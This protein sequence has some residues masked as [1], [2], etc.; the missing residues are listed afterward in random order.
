MTEANYVGFVFSFRKAKVGKSPG[1]NVL[2]F[3]S[4]KNLV[5]GWKK[6]EARIKKMFLGRDRN[7]LNN[8]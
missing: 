1:Q 2:D 7:N 5:D 3:S 8:F 4:F 6:R